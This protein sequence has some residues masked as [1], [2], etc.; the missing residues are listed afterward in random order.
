M[1]TCRSATAVENRERAYSAKSFTP[2]RPSIAW[3]ATSFAF[4]KRVRISEGFA[5][6]KIRENRK[7]WLSAIDS[8][9]TCLLWKAA[10]TRL[11]RL[12]SRNGKNR[13]LRPSKDHS[14]KRKRSRTRLQ[15]VLRQNGYWKTSNRSTNRN[16]VH[17]TTGRGL[18]N[19]LW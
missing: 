4:A 19:P 17:E 6:R 3:T 15:L 8:R 9:A 11:V 16:S 14:T 7:P 12:T 1:S 5:E 18:A 13:T 2:S 10:F